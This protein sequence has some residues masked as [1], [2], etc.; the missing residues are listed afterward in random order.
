MVAVVL[1]VAVLV[2]YCIM[3]RLVYCGYAPVTKHMVVQHGH[4]EEDVVRYAH[5]LLDARV[6]VD[7]VVDKVARVFERGGASPYSAVS[8]ALDMVARILVE[9]RVASSQSEV[10][11]VLE[12]QKT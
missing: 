8:S 7:E 10:D 9:R 3:L 1:G 2:A 11:S 6:R 5:Q 12:K 4:V